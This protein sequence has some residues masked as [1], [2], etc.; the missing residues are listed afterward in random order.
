MSNKYYKLYIEDTLQLAE[1]IVIKSDA[2]AASINEWI[3]LNHGTSAVDPNDK[4]SWKYYLN[5]C[6]EYHSTD[7]VIYITSL[8]TVGT[9]AF[10]KQNLQLHPTTKEAYRYGSRYYRELLLDYP[11][12]E[13]LILGVLYPAD[14][15][16]AVNSK[17]GTI[18]SYPSYLVEENEVSFKQKLQTWVYNWWFRWYNVQFNNNHG[19]YYMASKAVLHLSMVPEILNIRLRACRT[20]E[21]HSFHVREYLASH[22]GLDTYLDFMTRKQA[23]FFYRNIAYIERNNGKQDTFKWLIEKVLTDRGIPLSQFTMRHNV[24]KLPDEFYPEIVF[25]KTAVNEVYS[26]TDTQES[27]Y[28]LPTVLSK[29]TP[30]APY[31]A[32]YIEERG[33]SI[34]NLFVDSKSNVVQTKMLESSIIDYTD[35]TPYTLQDIGFNHWIYFSQLGLFNAYV[36]TPN[37]KTGVDI[38]LTAKEAFIYYMFLFAKS[39]GVSYNDIPL[40]GA[41]RVV[42]I[43]RVTVPEMMTVAD[44]SKI[45]ASKA[46][47]ILDTLP[48]IGSL[49]SINAFT[50]TANQLFEAAQKQIFI[51]SR[52]ERHFRRGMVHNL[53]NSLYFDTVL[54]F[55]NNTPTNYEE[56]VNDRALPNAELTQA[57]CQELYRNIYEAATGIPL[58]TTAQLGALQKAMINI[59]TQLSSYSIQFLAQINAASVRPLNWAMIRPDDLETI[60]GDHVLVEM[61]DTTVVDTHVVENNIVPIELEPIVVNQDTT[62]ITSDH[63]QIEIPV[64][65]SININDSRRIIEIN[66]M[67]YSVDSPFFIPPPGPGPVRYLPSYQQFYDLTPE[68]QKTIKSVYDDCFVDP[69]E[70]TH[71]DLADVLARD[72]LI[73]F[74]YLVVEQPV[75]NSFNF[76]YLPSQITNGIKAVISVDL[77]ALVFSGGTETIQG[78]FLNIG[79]EHFLE[80]FQNNNYTLNVDG[81]VFRQQ[82]I[83]GDLKDLEDNYNLGFTLPRFKLV[84]D[85]LSIDM[86][87]AQTFST[88]EIPLRYFIKE[89]ISMPIDVVTD[90]IQNQTDMLI[91]DRAN[92]NNEVVTDR[93]YS[94]LK[95]KRDNPQLVLTYKPTQFTSLNIKYASAVFNSPFDYTN[96][97]NF[98]YVANGPFFGNPRPISSPHYTAGRFVI[99]TG[100]KVGFNLT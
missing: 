42:R 49:F 54:D 59:M 14:M 24:A 93:L 88:F 99:N 22:G 91:T 47:E 37:P 35:S 61:P 73:S 7:E 26:Q 90:T 82:T 80:L 17:D 16:E 56:W 21:A 62:S 36:R 52:E 5:V 23:L 19:Y 38:V 11:D 92:L 29:E 69:V 30:L 18:I 48:A 67:S 95:F 64:K 87:S 85:S 98:S 75:L 53:V 44:S 77:D 65:P 51:V 96:R 9:I 81:L 32:K 70:N 94:S 89:K 45:P 2:E 55:T 97:I 68:E 6:G 33:Q 46:Q 40:F 66:M 12:K 13:Q 10:T 86:Q 15:N 84:T 63:Q 58:Q 3:T 25:R 57:E 4:T 71:I 78:G 50:N 76:V 27:N 60:E 41:M 28:S 34:L 79:Y 100:N 74:R 72:T 8:D 1:T 43:P 39:V 20:D 31:N 83:S